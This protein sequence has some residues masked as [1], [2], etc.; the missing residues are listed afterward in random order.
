[1]PISADRI[2]SRFDTPGL[3]SGS[4]RISR[5]PSVTAERIF[6]ADTFGSSSSEEAPVGAT[7]TCSS[8]CRRVLQVVI[9][10]CALTMCGSG[11]T[12]VSP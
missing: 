12:K 2:V 8:S 1:M 11:T 7:P 5:S 3:R 6:L 4:K 9:F 10:A